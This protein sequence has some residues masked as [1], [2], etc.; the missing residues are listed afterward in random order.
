MSRGP[1]GGGRYIEGY[2]VIIMFE[3]GSENLKI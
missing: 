2:V 3:F 1:W